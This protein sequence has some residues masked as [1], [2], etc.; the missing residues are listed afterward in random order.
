[1]TATKTAALLTT[2]PVCTCPYTPPEMWLSAV[3]CGYGS[4]YEPGSMQ[5]HD[6]LCPTHGS[7]M[8]WCTTCEQPS[9]VAE[10]SVETSGFEEQARDFHVTRLDC[11]HELAEPVGARR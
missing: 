11:G 2:D 7:P 10:T 5:E 6:P 1:M 9:R 3:S 4:G 8:E